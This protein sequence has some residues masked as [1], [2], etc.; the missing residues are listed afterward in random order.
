MGH[1][2]QMTSRRTVVARLL[3][4]VGLTVA[5]VGLPVPTFSFEPVAEAYQIGVPRLVPSDGSELSTSE[6]DHVGRGGRRL[7][8][9]SEGVTRFSMIGVSL[10]DVPTDPVM[11]RVRGTDGAWGEWLELD[12]DDDEG[13]D[14]TSVEGRRAATAGG[15]RTEPVW[16]GDAD[17]YELSI[18]ESDVE[19]ASVVVVRES[20]R[21][22]VVDSTPVASSGYDPF[23]GLHRRSEWTSRAR[24][25][26]DAQP[27]AKVEFAVVHHSVSSNTYSQAQVPAQ[28]RSI[29]AY[30]M[31]GN[32]WDDIGYNFVVD[33]FGGIWEGRQGSIDAAV[34]GAHAGGFNSGAVGVVVLGN[35]GATQ[36]SAAAKEAVA[37]VI[38]WKF[39]QFGTPSTGHTTRTSAGNVKYPAGTQ[40]TIPRVVGHRDVGSTAC[41]GTLH[42]HL[43]SIRE[44]SGDWNRWF[45]ALIR[46]FGNFDGV[47]VSN[48]SLSVRG[49]AVDPV[50]DGPATVRITSEGISTTVAANRSR[51]DVG[52]VHAGRTMSGFL[53]SL[54]VFAPG[55]HDVCVEIVSSRGAATNVSLG[56]RF[57]FVEDPTGTS[58]VGAFT[59]V[60][61]GTGVLDVAGWAFD[62]DSSASS[63]VDVLV[64]GAVAASVRADRVSWD[65]PPGAGVAAGTS[66][67]FAVRL[68]GVTG[69]ERTVCLR[70][71]NVGAGVTMKVDC[72]RV[73]VTGASPSGHVDAIQGGQR[74]VRVRGWALDRET[75]ASTKVQISIDGVR[76]EIVADRPRPDVAAVH[77]GYGAAHGFDLTLSAEPGN[78]TVCVAAVNVGQGSNRLLGCRNVTVVK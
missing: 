46:P 76:R 3:A 67:G 29:Q 74:S 66:H 53:G 17:G 40:V 57:V 28:I 6:H 45:S 25:N 72:R 27:A 55:V 31:D 56:C 38:G 37:K 51:P 33:R 54:G 21:R 36:A 73:R 24:R 47:D 15:H 12:V 35:Y 48:G 71:R 11:V 4:L 18:G 42:G 22:V 7:R 63:T 23:P 9:R 10:E 58:P 77:P 43:G 1:M 30:H 65:I 60:A 62:P 59:R 78:R 39:A 69:G 41:P 20:T 5:F 2:A 50:A 44:R 14:Q 49:W 16:V 68:A 61:P 13:P 34:V 52:A 70:P 32:G 64:D 8:G 19:G 26:P 75:T